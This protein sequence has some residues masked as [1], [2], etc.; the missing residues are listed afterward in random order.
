VT[1]ASSFI[2]IDKQGKQVK[3]YFIENR[4]TLAPVGIYNFILSKSRPE[5]KGLVLNY[6]NN[7]V[8]Y[9]DRDIRIIAIYFIHPLV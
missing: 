6:P 5:V 2:A 1:P 3:G 7:Y 8:F 4:K 9:N